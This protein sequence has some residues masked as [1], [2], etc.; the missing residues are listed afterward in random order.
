MPHITDTDGRPMAISHERSFLAQITCDGSRIIF[1]DAHPYGKRF[2]TLKN[3]ITTSSE[4]DVS[5]DIVTRSKQGPLYAYFIGHDDYTYTIQFRGGKHHGKY[6]RT[7]GN[8]NPALDAFSGSDSEATTFVLYDYDLN[9]ITLQDMRTN[10]NSVYLQLHQGAFIKKQFIERQMY[11][12]SGQWG[13]LVTFNLNIIERGFDDLANYGIS[14]AT[15][16]YLRW[17]SN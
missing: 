15:G 8:G 1:F 14:R 2:D 4:P 7:A 9:L 11:S 17:E 3:Q 13:N 12:Y 10:V 6:L 16:E 5:L